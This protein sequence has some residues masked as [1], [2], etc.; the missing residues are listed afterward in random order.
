M[1]H[2]EKALVNLI[3]KSNSFSPYI[4]IKNEE[5]IKGVAPTVSFTIQSDP[6]GEVGVNGCQASDM[7]EY[8]I[9]LFRSLNSAVPNR[10]TSITITKLEEALL[11]QD[12]RTA[13]RRDRD[14]EGT[15]KE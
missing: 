3:E 5:D 11:W 4:N 10:E 13:D 14:V 7:L 2:V 1:R 15:M 12:K 9:Y 8:L 6:V